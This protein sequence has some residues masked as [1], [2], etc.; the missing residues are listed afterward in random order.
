MKISKPLKKLQTTQKISGNQKGVALVLV[1]TVMSL[2]TI[3][4]LSFFS[5]ATSENQASATYSRGLQAQQ[6]A[7]Q[8]VNMVIAQIR[9]ASSQQNVAWASQP[10]AIRTWAS[11]GNFKMGYKLYSDDVL[12]EAAENKLVDD[13]FKEA[14]QWTS[15]PDE[16]VDLNEPVIRGERVYFPIVDPLA[17]ELPEWPDEIGGEDDTAGVE[18]FDFNFANGRVINPGDLDKKIK[19]LNNV[20]HLAMPV[21]W[22]YQLADGTLGTLQNGQF[23]SLLGNISPEQDNQIVARF[24]FWADDET[25]KLNLNVHAGGLAWDTPRAGGDMDMAMGQYQPLQKEFQRYPGHPATTHLVPA[26]APGVLD[27]VQDKNAMEMIFKTV[28][29]IVGGGSE[30]GTR[31]AN[32]KNEK[33]KN[34]LVP[35]Q[36]PLLPSVDEYVMQPDRDPTQFPQADGRPA[37][38]DEM[39]DMMERVRFFVTTSSRAP[40]TTL[41][42]TPRIACWPITGPVGDTSRMTAFD[43]LI[44]FCSTIGGKEYIFRRFNSDSED[45]DMYHSS[46]KRNPVLYDY[47]AKLTD[48]NIPGVGAAFSDKYGDKDRYQILTQIFDYIRSTNLHDDSLFG[49]DWGAAFQI[50]NTDDHLTYT[51]PR[52]K[53]PRLDEIGQTGVHKGHGQVTPIK[54]KKGSITTKGFG[55]FYTL[56]DVAI[57]AICV[58]DGGTGLIRTGFAEALGGAHSEVRSP[59]Y[60]VY[61]SSGYQGRDEGYQYSNFP[62]M[63][64]GASPGNPASYPQWLTDW[65]NLYLNHEGEWRQIGGANPPS[66]E[67]D[68]KGNWEDRFRWRNSSSPRDQSKN[69]ANWQEVLSIITPA[70]NP[71][72]WNWNLK[73]NRIVGTNYE[74]VKVDE[75]GVGNSDDNTLFD[76]GEISP[77]DF[78]RLGPHEKLVQAAMVFNLFCPSMGWVPIDPDMSIQVHWEDSGTDF[79]FTTIGPG[80]SIKPHNLD[81]A[82]DARNNK[83]KVYLDPN[84][85]GDKL[86]YGRFLV[87]RDLEGDLLPLDRREWWYSND[88]Q[89]AH[90]H[91]HSGG[92][93]PFTYMMRS[94]NRNLNKDFGGYFN[95]DGKELR[96]LGNRDSSLRSTGRLTPLDAEFYSPGVHEGN[97]YSFITAPFRIGPTDPNQSQADFYST[98]I[99]GHPKLKM[100]GGEITFKIYSHGDKTNSTYPNGELSAPQSD[101]VLVQTI[102][103]DFPG[104]VSH[105]PLLAEGRSG[106]INEFGE[107]EGH[108]ISPM[109]MWSLGLRG[110]Q[111]KHP[112]TNSF[113]MPGR[114]FRVSTQNGQLFHHADVV[115]SVSILH[116]DAR[117]AAV[118]EE[119]DDRDEIFGPHFRAAIY[120]NAGGLESFT[121]TEPEVA[122]WPYNSYLKPY[123]DAPELSFSRQAHDMAMSTGYRFEGGDGRANS[124]YALN[125]DLTT[126]REMQILPGLNFNNRLPA[127]AIGDPSK[128]SGVLVNKYGD[129][130]NNMGLLVDGCYINKPDEGNSHSLYKRTD[131]TNPNNYNMRRDFGDFPYF[132][133]DWVHEAGS[134]SYFSPNRIMSGP[135][136]FGSLP[137]GVWS[138]EPWQTL[139]FRPAAG[140]DHPGA[141]AS[142]GGQD[143]ADHYIMDLFWMPIVEPY[144]ISE[145]FSTAGKVNINYQILPFRNIKRNTSMRGIFRSE[146]MVLIPT[147]GYDREDVTNAAV[148]NYRKNGPSM[149]TTSYKHASGRGQ[150]WHWRDKPNGGFL[151]GKRLRAVI[152]ESKTLQQFDDKFEKDQEI[153]KSASEICEMHLVPQQVA[154]RLK[155]RS[156]Q[157]KLET[158]TPEVADMENGDYWEDHAA[159][160]D[161]SR[162]KPYGNIYNRIT[163]KSNTFKVH[164]RGQVL[165]QGRRSAAGVSWNWDPELDS[166]VGQYR[167]SSI[168][169]RYIDPNST[170][171]PDYANIIASS[172]NSLT[173]I[174]NGVSSLGEHYRFRVVNQTRFAP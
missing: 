156:L 23:K 120:D 58:A 46:M 174:L 70:F 109:E 32:Y 29:R 74:P 79:K 27:I 59:G 154:E 31:K 149:Y 132:V 44:A 10:G 19:E 49:E 42:N 110:A 77:Q 78:M 136:M 143:P 21:R 66:K 11:N 145:P 22:I 99:E 159:V 67:D 89:T 103:I 112:L 150:G 36:N 168:V 84:E 50:K 14:Q 56:R 13:D 87:Y 101:K 83:Q 165:K 17:K 39:S 173:S 9:K 133:R 73:Y 51:N 117:L 152:Q 164:Y 118:R 131:D 26:L 121:Q 113:A 141:S 155:T 57:H 144:A 130:D 38:V 161:N 20:G 122:G 63:H 147:P 124:S 18:G 169:E 72:N 55:R 170:L 3:M 71:D 111:P 102:E 172:S 134:P 7:E 160:G 82:A 167:G 98:S 4:I 115:Q 68:P 65:L 24:A 104:I 129:F 61:G 5:L 123:G 96:A 41:F 75:S 94:D 128:F 107:K 40:E 153:F 158:Y 64:E 93:L 140:T 33:E 106:N 166:V 43:E 1:L 137:T 100:R 126:E 127:N 116:G 76:Q 30:S 91:R 171:I 162:E 85:S 86:E 157:D 108:S 52:A 15:L 92:S 54:I 95:P 88:R 139:L 69:Q 60:T 97:Q 119:I 53:N 48:S 2:A 35:D 37:P 47:L 135:G 6:V 62:P 142:A 163:T 105:P 45:D 34:G 16:F 138:K 12:Q 8:A 81:N 114:L 28:P 148:G 80:G 125:K 151:Q 25:A 146:M 90:H